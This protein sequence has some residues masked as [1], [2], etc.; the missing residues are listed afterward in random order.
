MYTLLV[1]IG[2]DNNG[3]LCISATLY[4]YLCTDWFSTVVNCLT[5]SLL[6]Y[7][8]KSCLLT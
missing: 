2:S 7:K 8:R 1:H 6:P 5:M 3:N 4:F